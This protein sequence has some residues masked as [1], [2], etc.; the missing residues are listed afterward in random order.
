VYWSFGDI[1]LS[2]PLSCKCPGESI[3]DMTNGFFGKWIADF[4]PVDKDDFKAMAPWTWACRG[5]GDSEKRG[6]IDVAFITAV[7][8][9][10]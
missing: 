1:Y 10:I 4:L 7:L 5:P 6:L 2:T 9:R 3:L 8:C